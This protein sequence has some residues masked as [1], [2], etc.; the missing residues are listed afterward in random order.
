MSSID[1]KPELQSPNESPNN[2]GR[3]AAITFF[4]CVIG[5]IVSIIGFAFL[6]D[7]MYSLQW[8]NEQS[9]ISSQITEESCSID[10]YVPINCTYLCECENEDEWGCSCQG[11]LNGYLA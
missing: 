6:F 11:S 3:C 2:N 4:S 1:I 9:Q 7:S 10:S 5:T 8:A